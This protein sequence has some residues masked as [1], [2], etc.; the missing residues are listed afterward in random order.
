MSGLSAFTS[1]SVVDTGKFFM[2]NVLFGLGS[3]DKRQQLTHQENIKVPK[4]NT[5]YALVK[6]NIIDHLNSG[7][8]SLTMFFDL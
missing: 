7:R 8:T 6:I 5:T 1:A 4:A 3:D 2:N